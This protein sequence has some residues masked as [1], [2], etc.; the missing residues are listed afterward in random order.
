MMLSSGSVTNES[1]RVFDIAE[2]VSL[3]SYWSDLR[4]RAQLSRTCRTF[5]KAAAPHVWE[6]V[7]GIRYLLCLID[8]AVIEPIT[9]DSGA[10]ETISLN[11]SR[12][13]SQPFA[14]F[15]LYARFVKE[16]DLYGQ[17]A[18]YIAISGWWTLI[19]R[20]RQCG[21]LPNLHTL[22]LLH[23]RHKNGPDQPMW[24]QALGS[25]SLVTIFVGPGGLDGHSSISHPMTS[26]VL[27]SVLELC[28]KVRWLSLFPDAGLGNTGEESES[29]FL[30]LLSPEP[31]YTYLSGMRHLEQ[32]NGSVDWL[33]KE[34]IGMLGQIPNLTI[35]IIYGRRG[36]RFMFM[37]DWVSSESFINLRKL[38]LQSLHPYDASRILT[39]KNF[40]RRLDS[41]KLDF[42]I[43]LLDQ[44]I[45]RQEWLYR[46]IILPLQH[47]K[48]LVK[49]VLEANPCDAP[50]DLIEIGSEVL[51]VFSQLPLQVLCL[52]NVKFGDLC[53]NRSLGN[54]LPNVSVLE[55]PMQ[56]VSLSKLHCFTSMPKLQ[57]LLVSLDL[58]PETQSDKHIVPAWSAFNLKAS[59]RSPNAI[60]SGAMELDRVARTLLCMWPNLVMVGW[61]APAGLA[62]SPQEASTLDRLLF[63]NGYISTLRELQVLRNVTRASNRTL[64][65]TFLCTCESIFKAV[66]PHIWDHVSGVRFLLALIDG[67]TFEA[68]GDLEAVN[69]PSS[70]VTRQLFGRFDIYAP[71]VKSIAMYDTSG[72]QLKIQGWWTLISRNR[73]R[74]LLPNLRRVTFQSKTNHGPD[75]AMWVQAFG[76]HSITSIMSE[77]DTFSHP[78]P[79]VSYTMTSFLLKSISETCPNIQRLS[80]FPDAHVGGVG[81]DGEN[82]MLPLLS[83]EPFFNYLAGFYQLEQLDT[84]TAWLRADS[85]LALSQLPQLRTLAINGRPHDEIAI[86][87]DWF[88]PNAFPAL[89][90]LSLTRI[91]PE[92]LSNILFMGPLVGRLDSLELEFDSSLIEELRV[93][94]DEREWLYRHIIHPLQVI[95]TLTDLTIDADVSCQSVIQELG[96]ESLLVF[97][98]LPL[99][100]VHLN[101]F[102]IS[103]DILNPGLGLAWQNVT[104]LRMQK[105]CAKLSTLVSFA[106]LPALR[107]LEMILDLKLD[108]L[109]PVL[110][111]GEPVLSMTMLKA[112]TLGHE[113]NRICSGFTELDHVSRILL[114]LWP[115]L[116]EVQWSKP[117][118]RAS[119]PEELATLD[120]VNFLNGYLQTLR[121]LQSLRNVVG[122]PFGIPHP[123]QLL[124]FD[125][126]CWD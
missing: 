40:V 78:V 25:P 110:L 2:I 33:G 77:H 9:D 12:S 108:E 37:E 112:S 106:S 68:A 47:V 44:P 20:N 87:E 84:T 32:V 96:A 35:L 73:Q 97:Q 56:R 109:L 94:I 85:L 107:E 5:F 6:Y 14:R 30:T 90:T 113:E 60:C 52:T 81:Q 66:I 57:D 16:L 21:L 114:R 17:T 43:R 70:F 10:Y 121:E 1:S 53:L 50:V 63:L 28:P 19:S 126:K 62:I 116:K 67:V 51:A 111:P 71:L 120:R 102:K 13:V 125:F 22:V 72:K 99:E 46:K 88:P 39:A 76:S 54:T 104:V 69:L 124:P 115:N 24:I 18:V 38:T 93:D 105:Q 42:D 103:H 89:Q 34:P 91:H 3:I 8:G 86:L 92:D 26:L 29:Q 11:R 82:Y 61:P 15:D 122:A 58:R 55:L 95:K 83:P 31:F 23:T 119:T 7:P 117:F 100:T 36:H 45:N 79:V 101:G 4:E 59:H 123:F 74:T 118:R 80:C 98:H 48:G 75:I 41:V 64:D 65:W 49:F 27:K